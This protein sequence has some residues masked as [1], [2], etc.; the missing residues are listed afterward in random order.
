LLNYPVSFY[1]PANQDNFSLE[2]KV[3]GQSMPS[4]FFDNNAHSDG[5]QRVLEDLSNQNES[6]YYAFGSVGSQKRGAKM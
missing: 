5:G 6:T 2:E 4:Q 3:T 1:T